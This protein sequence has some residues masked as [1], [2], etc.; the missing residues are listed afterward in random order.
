MH[1]GSGEYDWLPAMLELKS[2]Y[3]PEI[4]TYTGREYLPKVIHDN[5]LDGEREAI[6]RQLFEP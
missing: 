2:R 5:G 3:R 1:S 4:M 6:L